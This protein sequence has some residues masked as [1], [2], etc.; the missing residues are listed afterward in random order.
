MTLDGTSAKQVIPRFGPAA[1]ADVDGEGA[2]FA[3]PMRLRARE[4]DVPAWARP[5]NREVPSAKIGLP[6]H[7]GNYKWVMNK[8]LLCGVVDSS[9]GLP[10]REL[11]FKRNGK[12]GAEYPALF[13]CCPYVPYCYERD[14]PGQPTSLPP[15][16]PPISLLPAILMSRKDQHV[17]EATMARFLPIPPY[18]RGAYWWDAAASAALGLPPPLPEDAS[19]AD[20]VAAP[21]LAALERAKVPTRAWHWD[22]NATSLVLTQG[23]LEKPR[24]MDRVARLLAGHASVL[25]VC[26]R[27]ECLHDGVWELHLR[28]RSPE[29][30]VR[31]A[32]RVS[33]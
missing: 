13:S 25:D 28:V 19:A 5:V 2:K 4:N 9:T 15:N 23:A 27:A 14:R 17:A 22:A 26:A 16:Q 6:E 3:G 1:D 32:G 8:Y 31:V 18:R 7:E 30:P 24:E 33:L 20:A 10:V 11:F 21:M 12:Y 29:P